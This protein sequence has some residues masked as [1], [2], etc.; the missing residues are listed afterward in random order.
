MVL[1]QQFPANDHGFHV[2]AAQSINQLRI[3]IVHGRGVRAIGVDKDQI[4]FFAGFERADEVIE[5]K[6]ARAADGGHLDHL[7]GGKGARV[8]ARDFLQFCG[9]V[10]FLKNV[11]AVV[12]GGAV[13][14][15]ADRM[16][17]GKKIDDGHDTGGE[18]HVAGGIVDAADGKFLQQR[19]VLG[20]DPDAMR[21]DHV[22]TEETDFCEISDRRAAKLFAALLDFKWRLGDV[23]EDGRAVLAR[24]SGRIEQCFFAA[25]IDGVRRDGRNNERI[26][27]PIAQI[28]F[29]VA[30][31]VGGSFVVG[32]G[33]VD[34]GFDP[35]CRAYPFLL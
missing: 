21:A 17:D 31:R 20:I 22:R 13:G 19:D 2:R 33:K 30:Q 6:C 23:D 26:V 3:D 29:G 12:A 14:G 28:L 27:L 15:Q 1:H 18:L 35:G 5:V 25:S 32:R 11:L 4:G 9:G 8:H 34:D 10:H 7:D 24:E 16:A